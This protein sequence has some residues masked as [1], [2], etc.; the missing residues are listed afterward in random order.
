ME[1]LIALLGGALAMTIAVVAITMLPW[2]GVDDESI[3]MKDGEN[4][5]IAP[6]F[7]QLRDAVALFSKLDELLKNYHA[8]YVHDGAVADSWRPASGVNWLTAIPQ[9]DHLSANAFF[10]Y[11]GS[12]ISESSTA[13]EAGSFCAVILTDEQT[14]G[15]ILHHR[16]SITSG[17]HYYEVVLLSGT[18]FSERF[19]YRFHLP[20]A[21]AVW[22]QS[23]GAYFPLKIDDGFRRHDGPVT[24]VFPDPYLLTGATIDGTVVPYSRF[25]YFISQ[26]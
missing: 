15:G 3:L 23:P 14:V 11:A 18:G 1:A 12:P 20:Q 25:T 26:N 10:Q 6:S 17:I 19:E 8:F 24:L 16:N 5:P 4:Y 22:G 13:G 9:R 7:N 2:G 21:E